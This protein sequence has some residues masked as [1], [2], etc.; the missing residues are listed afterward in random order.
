MYQNFTQWRY[1]NK[2]PKKKKLWYIDNFSSPNVQSQAHD[3]KYFSLKKNECSNNSQNSLEILVW[4]TGEIGIPKY[5]Y[6]S[7]LFKDSN[8]IKK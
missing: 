4:R 2:R 3:V 8:T 5:T 1:K 6:F 7:K